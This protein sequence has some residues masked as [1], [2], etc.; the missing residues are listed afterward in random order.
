[1]VGWPADAVGRKRT[2]ALLA[3]F[4]FVSAVGCG[5]AWNWCSL[6]AFRFIGGLA[7]GGASVVSPMY[8]AEICAGQVP[9]T[10]RG[11]DAVQHRS[12]HSAGFLFQL[13]DRQL[14]A[15]ADGVAV[16]V[17][18]AGGA[19]GRLFLPAVP[20][21]REPA[22]AG[23]QEAGDEARSVLASCGTDTPAC[24]RG[25][26]GDRPRWTGGSRAGES[27]LQ[28]KYRSRSCWRSRSRC[29]TSSRA[30]TP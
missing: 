4:Y 28:A 10:A 16:D 19:L 26:R 20:D 3:V 30:S 17:G 8:I 5:L 18:H 14:D 25:D 1:M 7:V 22:L 21:A 12:G 6:L 11:G 15:R 13:R 29:S 27:F 9:R 23:L 24:R 2:L